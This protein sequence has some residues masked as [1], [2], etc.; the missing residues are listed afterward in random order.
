M[1]EF[2]DKTNRRIRKRLEGTTKYVYGLGRELARVQGRINSGHYARRTVEGELIPERDRLQLTID[3]EKS[4]AW[5]DAMGIV[6]NYRKCT[7]D[8]ETADEL[9]ER[10]ADFIEHQMGGRQA[11]D[12]LPLYFNDGDQ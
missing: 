2:L 6:E 12:M 8:H 9:A 10:V 1:G 5:R 3:A 4:Y 11:L 7:H